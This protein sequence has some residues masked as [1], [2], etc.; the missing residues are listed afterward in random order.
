MKE[1]LKVTLTDNNKSWMLR[2]LWAFVGNR[3]S[4]MSILS[5]SF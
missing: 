1:H 5:L 2:K 3:V 4:S